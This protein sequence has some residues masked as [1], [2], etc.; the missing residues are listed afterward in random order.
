MIS[1]IILIEVQYLYTSRPFYLVRFS[2]L[3]R[4]KLVRPKVT[5][6]RPKVT[7]VRPKVTLVRPKHD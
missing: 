3:V 1:F 7:L 2:N 4:L 6:V 5:L